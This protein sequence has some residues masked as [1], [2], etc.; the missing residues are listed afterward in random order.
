MD[1]LSDS[2]NFARSAVVTAGLA[3]RVT[4]KL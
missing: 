2:R 4:S 1:L 3:S